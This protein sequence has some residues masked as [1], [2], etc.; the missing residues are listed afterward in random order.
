MKPLL[1]L[2]KVYAGILIYSKKKHWTHFHASIWALTFFYAYFILK[3][4]TFAFETCD[5]LPYS[6]FGC[7]I[8]LHL[9]GAAENS[10]NFIESFGW[11]L[12]PKNLLFPLN[13][14][15]SILSYGN[16]LGLLFFLNRYHFVFLIILYFFS[17][18]LFFVFAFGQ[19]MNHT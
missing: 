15:N 10:L 1:S 14:W 3:R 11:A 5:E 8:L 12:F 16:Y 17:F 7:T 9:F 2:Q 4:P 6:F 18:Y 19:F 13:T